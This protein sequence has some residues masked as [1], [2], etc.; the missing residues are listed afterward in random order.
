MAQDTNAAP[1]E[2]MGAPGS[3]YTRKLLALLRYRRIEHRI[4]WGSYN[5]GT[6]AYPE[7]K[8][9]LLPTVYFPKGDGTREATV[10]TTPIIRRLETDH[11]GRS[12]VPEDPALGFVNDLIEDYADEWLTKAMFHYRWA[13]QDD[14]ANAGPLLIFWQ[15]PGLA[16][17]QARDLAQ[18]I[19]ERQISRLYVVG[20]NETTAQTI[21]TSYKRLL[22]LLDTLLQSSPYVLGQRPSSADF[23][24]YG[25]LTQLVLVD[26]TPARVAAE[27][28]PRIRG[29]IDRIDDLSGLEPGPWDGLEQA[30]ERLGPLLHEIGRVYAPFLIANASAVMAGSE[31][32]EATIDGRPWTQ[33][34]FAY[35]AK[36]LGWLREGYAAL[37]ASARA[38]VDTLL[39]GT[40][41]EA[42]FAG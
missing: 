34:V 4:I 33:P 25:Q 27:I 11:A 23:A 28:A 2:L 6:S 40:G 29:W 15:D 1:L 38:N 20:S 36:C 9:K 41:C 17:D 30:R 19:S 13:Y 35:Q 5:R 14:I 8:V 18:M 22:T 12:A 26:P 16:P 24:L 21:E 31:T 37:P 7:P 39:A 32:V 10:D 3:P 42:L